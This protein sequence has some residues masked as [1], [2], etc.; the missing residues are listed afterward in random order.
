MDAILD[1]PDRL[2]VRVGVL[3]RLCDLDALVEPVALPL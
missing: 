3:V 1:V 2:G